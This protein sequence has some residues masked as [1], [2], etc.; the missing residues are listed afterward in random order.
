M[1]NAPFN[2][3]DGN[4]IQTALNAVGQ[5]ETDGNNRGAIVDWSKATGLP[6]CAG[7]VCEVFDSSGYAA[8]FEGCSNKLYVPTVMEHGKKHGMGD[9]IGDTPPEVGSV[10]SFKNQSHIGIV[11]RVND[12]GSF[13]ITQGNTSNAV[14]T[15]S[16]TMKDFESGHL[17]KE[18]IS[19]LK[20]DA[21]LQKQGIDVPS[22]SGSYALASTNLPNNKELKEQVEENGMVGAYDAIKERTPDFVP[23]TFLEFVVA[24]ILTLFGM[25]DLIPKSA[26]YDQ[27]LGAGREALSQGDKVLSEQKEQG[28]DISESESVS[29]SSTPTSRSAQ[30]G[31]WL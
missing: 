1:N 10:V 12:D 29:P 3:I 22:V 2:I 9:V 7:F 5:K 16:Y 13:E 28:Q 23:E 19:A 4:I 31:Q 26:E 15:V 30:S 11:T 14:K 18:Y 8:V 24:S 20:M 25:E 6:W 17:D 21:Y 27:N